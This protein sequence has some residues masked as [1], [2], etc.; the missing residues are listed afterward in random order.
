MGKWSVAGGRLVGGSVV[1]GFNKTHMRHE[2]GIQVL[3]GILIKDF[4]EIYKE[5]LSQKYCL[6]RT[7]KNCLH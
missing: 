7:L 2:C 5:V 1:G 3:Y 4:A 6:I